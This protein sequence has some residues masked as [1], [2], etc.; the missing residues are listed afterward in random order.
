MILSQFFFLSQKPPYNWIEKIIN[1]IQVFPFIYL[2]LERYK[3][4]WDGLQQ[5]YSHLAVTSIV[6]HLSD[7]H[8]QSTI[9]K[10][11]VLVIVVAKI[12]KWGLKSS[13]F[14]HSLW[15]TRTGFIWVPKQYLL[16]YV[17][18]P[19]T[20]L[21]NSQFTCYPSCWTKFLFLMIIQT[22]NLCK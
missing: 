2:D 12:F 21:P 13:K 22:R 14:H 3:L 18:A 11:T 16:V 1:N 8:K 15:I 20:A 9:E 17:Y 19:K 7:K 4:F 5:L 10:N 6:N